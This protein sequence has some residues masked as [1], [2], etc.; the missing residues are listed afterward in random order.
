MPLKTNNNKNTKTFSITI[1]YNF[2]IRIQTK[3]SQNYRDPNLQT[4]PGWRLFRHLHKAHWCTIS[5]RSK[6]GCPYTHTYINT[7]THPHTHTNKM[8]ITQACFCLRLLKEEKMWVWKWVSRREKKPKMRCVIQNHHR[9]LGQLGEQE[10]M[11][12]VHTC[13]THTQKPDRKQA[14]PLQNPI[15]CNI[16][17]RNVKI[18]VNWGY[19]LHLS[20]S[21]R[22]CYRVTLRCDVGSFY[23]LFYGWGSA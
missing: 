5:W 13:H 3:H 19:F 9:G 11:S 20:L 23:T 16:C 1:I 14:L 10:S 4:G 7:H 15:C 22:T 17:Q 2:F 21:P 8:A 6:T 12:I 18:S